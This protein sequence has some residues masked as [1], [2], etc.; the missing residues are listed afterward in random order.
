MTNPTDSGSIDRPSRSPHWAAVW[1]GAAVMALMLALLGASALLSAREADASSSFFARDGHRAG[2]FGHHRRHPRDPEAVRERAQQGAELMLRLVDAD[3][4]QRE[5]VHEIVGDAVDELFALVG[6]HRERHHAIA[7]ALLAE[8]IDR[9][10]LEGLRAAEL[11]VAEAA[12]QRLLAAV[13]DVAE[14][15]TPEQRGE[16]AEWVQRFHH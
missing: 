16:L 14:V 13:A 15:L 11:E 8:S 4:A 5:Q 12:S 3:A 10:R 7:T 1:I 9:E 2:W 6:P